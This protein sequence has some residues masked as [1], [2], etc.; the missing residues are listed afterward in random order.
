MWTCSQKNLEFDKKIMFELVKSF[1]FIIPREQVDITHRITFKHA[2][3]E[4]YKSL[5]SMFVCGHMEVFR[6]RPW[7]L[8]EIQSN[9]ERGGISV[10]KCELLLYMQIRL[11]LIITVAPHKTSQAFQSLDNNNNKINKDFI[12]YTRYIVT[13]HKLM[14]K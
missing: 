10:F 6:L 4:K 2:M 8:K 11:F 9:P 7:V 14:Y 3:K 1:F 12:P 5:C 13:K